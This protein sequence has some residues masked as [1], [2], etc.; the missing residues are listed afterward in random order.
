VIVFPG[1]FNWPIWIAQE[2]GYFAKGGI[3][4][5]LTP[6]PNSVFQLTNL[7][8]GKFDIAMTAVDNVIAYMEGQGEAQTATKPDL[9]VFMGG[10]NGFLSLVAVPE[11]K[12]ITDLRGRTVSVDALTTGYAFVLLD[13]LKRSGLSQSGYK[14]EKAGG[15]LARWEALKE[16][17]HD[18]TML[19][20]PFD[21][22]ARTAGLNV[23]KYAIEVYGHYQGICGAARREWAS[24]NPELV[25]AYIRGYIAGVDFLRETRN[26]DYA[27]SILRKNLPQV[28]EQ[29]A[30]QIHTT[31]TGSNGF[32]PKAELDFDGVRRVLAL[33]SEYGHPKK[34]M[35][36]P[37][38]YYLA[39]YYREAINSPLTGF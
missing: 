1:G 7:I 33:R 32:A 22:F 31:M 3:D 6:T 10:D 19:I 18:A 28:S 34:E 23:L 27:C 2:K 15:V 38:R 29:I 9:I 21:I 24:R 36:D 5:V 16:K 14:I 25:K 20:T 4:V 17:K 26:K 35:N 30:S 39:E 37:T 13:L 12:N 8:D 11:V